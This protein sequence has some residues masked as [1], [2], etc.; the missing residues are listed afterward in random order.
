M[1]LEAMGYRPH[2]QRHILSHGVL[3]GFGIWTAAILMAPVLATMRDV[4]VA[5]LR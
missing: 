5:A 3:T 1:T 4:I 2:T